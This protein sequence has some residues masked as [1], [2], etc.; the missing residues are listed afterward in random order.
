MF[1]ERT[2][3]DGST[4]IVGFGLARNF[5]PAKPGA[6]E[7]A[8]ARFFPEAKVLAYDWHDWVAD[9]Y[10]RG[11]WIAPVLGKEQALAP[12]TWRI[13]GPLAFASSDISPE[14]AGWFEGAMISGLGAAR[15]LAAYLRGS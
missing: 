5:D 11:T 14:G 3:L 13:T 2:S 12:Q 7:T 10:A 8:V 9:P 1:S 6:V 15:D 4:L